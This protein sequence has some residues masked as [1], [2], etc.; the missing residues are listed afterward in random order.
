M[1]NQFSHGWGGRNI[2]RGVFF[3]GNYCNIYITYLY[4]IYSLDVSSLTL[5][6]SLSPS[7]PLSLYMY[8]CVSTHT[9]THTHIDI[10]GSWGNEKPTSQRLE[11][12]RTLQARRHSP[13][14][15]HP[16][17]RFSS[18]SEGSVTTSTWHTHAGIGRPRDF[19]RSG[20]GGSPIG[21]PSSH[22][23]TESR[24]YSPITVK[25]SCRVSIHNYWYDRSI[26]NADWS[27][28][29]HSHGDKSETGFQS[30]LCLEYEGF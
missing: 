7:L 13:S 10:G 12:I 2:Q 14:K 28:L 4:F 17:H 1:F 16:L 19:T 3:K 22:T 9:H 30:Y 23:L 20:Q 29:F 27:Q 25:S 6:L 26:G 21:T 11:Q 15:A 5:S 18:H 8:I 24:Y